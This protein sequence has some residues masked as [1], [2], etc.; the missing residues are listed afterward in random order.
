MKIRVTN[1][2]KKFIQARTKGTAYIIIS[3]PIKYC[4]A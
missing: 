3:A 2:A 1:E 4:G